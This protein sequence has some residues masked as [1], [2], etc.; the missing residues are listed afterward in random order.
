MSSSSKC[1]KKTGSVLM[2]LSQGKWPSK[3]SLFYRLKNCF[4]NTNRK[5]I[6]SSV[7]LSNQFKAK[8]EIFMAVP[9]FSNVY[10]RSPKKFE[11]KSTKIVIDDCFR[12]MQLYWSM[13]CKRVS[14][15]LESFGLTNISIFLNHRTSSHFPRNSKPV[16]ILLRENFNPNRLISIHWSESIWTLCFLFHRSSLIVFSILGWVNRQRCSCWMRF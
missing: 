7:L 14:V 15:Q 5:K 10:N 3:L 4:I 1:E 8:V 12:I 6:L 2:R 13:K 16:V 9:H 11:F